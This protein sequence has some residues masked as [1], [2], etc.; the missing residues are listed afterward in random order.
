MIEIALSGLQL[1]SFCF[2][3]L[4]L[5][6][7]FFGLPLSFTFSCL[8]F[9]VSFCVY[10]ATVPKPLLQ[11]FPPFALLHGTE[12]LA[13]PQMCQALSCFR[14]VAPAFPFTSSLLMNHSLTSSTSL[15]NIVSS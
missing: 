4:P 5:I 9:S 14:A 7:D 10:T 6:L 12:L 11:L 3:F 2:I 15:L 1:V 13:Y 8:S